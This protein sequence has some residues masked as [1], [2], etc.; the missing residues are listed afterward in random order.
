MLKKEMK[1]LIV[2]LVIVLKINVKFIFYKVGL[3]GLVGD[4]YGLKKVGVEIY[5]G[6]KGIKF[7]GCLFL[8][9]LKGI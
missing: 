8:V 2:F 5:V 1:M 6:L 3:K 9:R 7:V 4:C